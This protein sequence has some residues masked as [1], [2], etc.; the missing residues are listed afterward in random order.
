[1]CMCVCE[2]REERPSSSSS[3]IVVCVRVQQN[4]V[5]SLSSHA[6]I[7]IVVACAACP[8]SPHATHLNIR[9]A[10]QLRVL[11]LERVELPLQAHEIAK[12]APA[13]IVRW[14]DH[15]L[16]WR[17]YVRLRCA[18]ERGRALRCK[19]RGWEVSV[20]ASLVLAV[21]CCACVRLTCTPRL[22]QQPIQSLDLF[23][24]RHDRGV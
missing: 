19:Q 17:R 15:R 3:I 14:R 23:L 9:R 5:L 2:R 10:P 22:L 13:S 8:L 1:M 24:E 12:R 20:A 21:L 6:A 4:D 11:L 16:R 7:I 18:C